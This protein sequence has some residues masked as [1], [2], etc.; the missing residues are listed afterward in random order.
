[1]RSKHSQNKKHVNHIVYFVY[2]T[3]DDIH[4]NRTVPLA[5]I[6]IRCASELEFVMIR[7]YFSCIMWSN[8][9]WNSIDFSSTKFLQVF[10][11][12]CYLGNKRVNSLVD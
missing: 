9:F 1:M 11:T 8:R 2:P 3:S 6:K 10:N 4:C 5:N 12:F 7:M